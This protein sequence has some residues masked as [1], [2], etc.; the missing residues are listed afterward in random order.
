VRI[1][2]G[3][4]TPVEN[5]GDIFLAQTKSG[6]TGIDIRLESLDLSGITRKYI[7]LEGIALIVNE[8]PK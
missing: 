5:Q 4:D 1:I 6:F 2:I 7:P 3:N 8:D